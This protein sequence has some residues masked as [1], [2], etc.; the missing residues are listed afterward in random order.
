M[1]NPQ[2]P[3]SGELMTCCM[4]ARQERSH[5]TIKTEWRCLEVDGSRF[6]ACPREFPPDGASA[7]AFKLAYSKILERIIRQRARSLN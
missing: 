3:F 4:C 5:P 6:Y 1:T 2:P 7:K